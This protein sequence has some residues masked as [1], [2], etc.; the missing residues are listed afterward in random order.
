[1]EGEISGTKCACLEHFW[2]RVVDAKTWSSLAIDMSE[3]E[4]VSLTLLPGVSLS[5]DTN[6]ALE[7]E[8]TVVTITATIP[9]PVSGDQTV[10]LLVRQ[11]RV[12]D[13]NLQ[14]FST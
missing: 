12:I 4:D 1:M 6:S 3:V 9:E 5:V 14:F 10:D 2:D 11:A 7:S 8:E 13:G